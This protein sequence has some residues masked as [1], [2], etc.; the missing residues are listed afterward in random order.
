M[1]KLK[2]LID[3][4]VSKKVE[5]YLL[6]NGYDT[7]TVRAINPRISD[8]EILKIGILSILCHSELVSESRF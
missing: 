7:K 1:K 3:V 6:L 2:F 5:E 8:I 4:G